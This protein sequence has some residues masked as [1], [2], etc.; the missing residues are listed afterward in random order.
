MSCRPKQGGSAG[1]EATTPYSTVVRKHMM[2]D[3]KQFPVS[4]NLALASWESPRH[5]T[6]ARF[7]RAMFPFRCPDRRVQHANSIVRGTRI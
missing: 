7:F 1:A 3:L 2:L 4:R 6:R 5:T